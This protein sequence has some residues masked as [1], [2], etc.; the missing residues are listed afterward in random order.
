MER[1]PPIEGIEPV[2]PVEAVVAPTEDEVKAAIQK[3]GVKLTDMP[4]MSE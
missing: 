3:A 1:F 2:E 4:G